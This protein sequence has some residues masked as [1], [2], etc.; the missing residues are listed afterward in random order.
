MNVIVLERYTYTHPYIH[1]LLQQ[2]GKTKANTHLSSPFSHLI[3]KIS[4]RFEK[5]N[6]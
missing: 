4:L 3:F 5:S 6:I 2:C 1:N